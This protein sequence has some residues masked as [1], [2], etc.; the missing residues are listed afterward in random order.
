M[1]FEKNRWN[2]SSPLQLIVM[3]ATRKMTAFASLFPFRSRGLHAVFDRMYTRK[4]RSSTSIISSID[5]VDISPLRGPVQVGAFDVIRDSIS[6]VVNPPPAPV[7]L[8]RRTLDKD[9]AVSL[10]RTGYNVVDDLDFVAMDDFQKQFF[11]IRSKEWEKFIKTNLGMRQG[12]L[13]DPRYFDFISYAQMLT[14]QFFI[15]DPRVIFEERYGDENGHWY[16]RVVRRDLSRLATSRDILQAW[17]I[18]VG[19]SIYNRIQNT[20]NSPQIVSNGDSEAILRGIRDIYNYIE[21]CGFCLQVNVAEN[22]GGNSLSVEMIAPCILWGAKA[23]KR[24]R[25]V[26]NDYDCYAVEAFCQASGVTPTYLT[27]FSSSSVT[28][29]WT[30]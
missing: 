29:V 6:R 13:T 23:L 15:R 4:D 27:L 1:S 5:E 28:R 30:I 20:F 14:I 7:V 18:Q 25:S 2:G 17:R 9:F 16:T 22:G 21:I 12:I 19:E 3:P 11:D 10:M 26:P 8:A 24:L